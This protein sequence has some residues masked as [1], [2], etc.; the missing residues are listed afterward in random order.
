M[1]S[2]WRA[3]GVRAGRPHPSTSIR[4]RTSA[5]RSQWFETLARAG[6]PG[7]LDYGVYLTEYSDVFR[8]AGPQLLLLGALRVLGA[9]GR[10]AGKRA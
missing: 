10:L 5:S 9:A 1:R 6:K 4:R 3:P 7:P 8:L 2:W